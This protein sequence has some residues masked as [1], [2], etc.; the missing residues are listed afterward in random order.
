MNK[1]SIMSHAFVARSVVSLCFNDYQS[2]VFLNDK[3]SQKNETE[4]YQ[5]RVL[6]DFL[7]MRCLMQ[8]KRSC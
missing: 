8:M 7:F 2:D 4:S 1:M 3:L 6:M 5:R